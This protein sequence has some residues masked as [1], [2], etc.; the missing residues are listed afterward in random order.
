MGSRIGIELTSIVK[1]IRQRLENLPFQV[2]VKELADVFTSMYDAFSE[3]VRPNKK[4]RPIRL[5][6]ESVASTNSERDTKTH[7]H[8]PLECA[9]L[10]NTPLHNV[11]MIF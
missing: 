9:E 5:K 10:S 3:T 1:I 8:M 11:L 2:A 7:R 4:P 6:E